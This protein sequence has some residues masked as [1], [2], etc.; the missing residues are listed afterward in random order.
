M[1]GK[2]PPIHQDSI[3]PLRKKD[4]KTEGEKLERRDLLLSFP[5]ER[6]R[7]N[8]YYVDKYYKVIYV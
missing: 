7:I 1:N 2:L 6:V 8:K 3:N 5:R 4:L